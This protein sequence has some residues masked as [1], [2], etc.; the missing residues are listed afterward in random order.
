MTAAEP[1][2]ME[3]GFLFEM[4][5]TLH[6]IVS[7][8]AHSDVV[9]LSVFGLCFTTRRVLCFCL[10]IISVWVQGRKHGLRCMFTGLNHFR[11][12][13]GSAMAMAL[14]FDQSTNCMWLQ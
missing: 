12:V 6:I 14:K 10:S 2:R 1:E 8:T 4:A 11:I 3:V 9:Y 5:C 13:P 7:M